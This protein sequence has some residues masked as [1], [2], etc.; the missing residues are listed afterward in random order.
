MSAASFA[1]RAQEVS[2]GPTKEKGEVDS[3]GGSPPG[4]EREP[5]QFVGTVP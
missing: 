4:P 2:V 3:G 5:A 1:P